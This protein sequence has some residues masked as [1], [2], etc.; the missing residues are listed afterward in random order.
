[1]SQPHQPATPQWAEIDE[2]ILAC[3]P[4]G[5]YWQIR[6]LIGADPEAA[7]II[8]RE[9]FRQ[10]KVE[11]SGEFAWSRYQCGDYLASRWA[12]V[13]YW[14]E[15]SLV[16]LIVPGVEVEETRNLLVVGHPGVDGIQFGYRVGHP[17]LW[18]YK[19][20]GREVSFMAATVADLVE[21][22]VS[23]ELSV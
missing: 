14:D 19:P 17:G 3:D 12:D 15:S 18:A 1:M 6:E 23:G 21:K 22:W 4:R 13:G 9:R 8:R 7:N 5:A 11:R 10:L 16:M 2:R 20:I